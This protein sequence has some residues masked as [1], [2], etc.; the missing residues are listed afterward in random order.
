MVHDKGIARP[1]ILG[2]LGFWFS[3]WLLPS[4]ESNNQVLKDS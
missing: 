4:K 1:D 2:V 3:K